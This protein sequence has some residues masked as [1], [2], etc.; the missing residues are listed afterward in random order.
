MLDT[1]APLV[2]G[3]VSCV[4]GDIFVAHALGYLAF[5]A[6]DVVRR[7][8]GTRPLEPLYGASVGALR[9]VDDDDVYVLG[10]PVAVREVSVVRLVPGGVTV[11]GF[12]TGYIDLRDFH[13][14]RGEL[15]H[16]PGRDGRGGTALQRLVDLDGVELG[17]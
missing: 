12:G 4:P 11:V 6:H 14:L 15:Q 16:L 7:D 1:D 5:P 17:V 13:V 2:V 8:V 10:P 9:H 3:P